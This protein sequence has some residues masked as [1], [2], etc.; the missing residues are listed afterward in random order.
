[1]P[2]GGESTCT[3]LNLPN[4]TM[5]D[6]VANTTGCGDGGGGVIVG[7]LGRTVGS[8]PAGVAEAAGD[9]DGCGDGVTSAC[10]LSSGRATRPACV[11]GPLAQRPAVPKDAAPTTIAAATMQHEMRRR[12]STYAIA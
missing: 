6:G 12:R 9:G 1:M 2:L 10:G 3:A 8:G 4:C 11:I 5:I 7:I